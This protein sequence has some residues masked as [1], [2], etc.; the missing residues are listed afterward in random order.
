M[1][2]RIEVQI[3][4][5][6]QLPVLKDT[7]GMASGVSNGI[8]CEDKKA[9]D[10]QEG[11]SPESPPSPM[12]AQKFMYFDAVVRNIHIRVFMSSWRTDP[13]CYAISFY[14]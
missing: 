5:P 12:V 2:E 7:W 9:S 11:A 13:F 3:Q 10:T 1:G 14:S 6:M 4:R 8:P